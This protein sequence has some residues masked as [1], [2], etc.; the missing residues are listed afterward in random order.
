MLMPKIK[1]A[2]I[3]YGC[4]LLYL[5]S[6]DLDCAYLFEMLCLYSNFYTLTMMFI[7]IDNHR[8]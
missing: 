3:S 8:L 4:V 5:K 7:I 1:D 2:S 6:F